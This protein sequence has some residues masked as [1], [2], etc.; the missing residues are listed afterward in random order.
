MTPRL[1]EAL[2]LLRLAGRDRDTFDLLFPLERADP[3]VLGFHA[4]QA[5]EKALKA[6]LVHSGG[7]LLRTHDLV[8]LGH[9]VAARGRALPVS[10]ESLRALNPFAVEY[11][12]D[13][14]SAPSLSRKAMA[15]TLAAVVDW[16]GDTVSG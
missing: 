9:E 8:A 3:V 15:A 11:R 2:R 13:D 4:Q 7:D 12:Y 6:A 5:V 16:A 1:E 10:L 14:E